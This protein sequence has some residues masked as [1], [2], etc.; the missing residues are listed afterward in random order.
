MFE[1]SDLI[2]YSCPRCGSVGIS[3][4]S[5][6]ESPCKKIRCHRCDYEG[7]PFVKTPDDELIED[8]LSGA[9]WTCPNCGHHAY[10][11]S[12]SYASDYDLEDLGVTRT[13]V[14]MCCGYKV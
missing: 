3:Q 8:E 6:L 14:C 13:L 9:G 1:T 7:S 4:L 10:T 2:T 5:E 11:I 12:T